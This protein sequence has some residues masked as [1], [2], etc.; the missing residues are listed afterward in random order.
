MLTWTYPWIFIL[1]PL[2]WLL[3]WL[4][5]MARPAFSRALKIPF[6]N[7]MTSMNV[8]SSH[9]SLSYLNLWIAFIIWCLLLIAAANPQWLGEPIDLQR[10]GRNLMLA[11]DLS[12]SMEIRDMKLRG[13]QVDRLQVIKAVAEQFI[14]KRVGDRLGLILFGTRAYLQTPLTFDRKTV[15]AMLNDATI[16]LPGPLTA[17]GDAIG[18]AIKRLQQYP[19][20][21]RVLILLT[22]GQSNSGAVSPLDAAKVAAK[23][24]IRIY[25]IGLGADRLVIPTILGARVVNPSIEL[26]EKGLREIAQ[27]TGGQYFRARDFNSLQRIYTDLNQLEPIQINQNRYRPLTPLYPWPL[28]LAFVMAIVLILRG[29]PV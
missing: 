17:I 27:L 2:P 20:Q 28:G 25:T 22:D 6:F 12:G 10:T 14:Q 9:P 24:G 15:S 3:R 23:E 16:A 29:R 4:L 13:Q 8:D 19:K 18:L 5:P 21:S 11:I 1:I 26:D 7:T